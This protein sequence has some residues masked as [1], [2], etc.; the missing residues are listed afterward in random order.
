MVLSDAPF[1]KYGALYVTARCTCGVEKDVNLRMMEIGRT[2]QCKGCSSRATHIGRGHLI[3]S[4][5]LVARLQKRA[6]AML[7][8]CSNPNDPSYHNYGGRGVEFRFASVKECVDYVLSELPH[9]SYVGLDIDRVNNNGH[10]EP[11]NLRLATRKQN[12]N[13]R[14]NTRTP[15]STTS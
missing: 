6:A 7:Q 4:S 13:N 8:R 5:Q 2:T 12:L 9:E 14:R 1:T 15:V 10:Y 3:I 11:G